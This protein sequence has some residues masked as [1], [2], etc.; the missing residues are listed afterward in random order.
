MAC[1]GKHIVI[2]ATK[3]AKEKWG[4]K[5]YPVKQKKK[6]YCPSCQ[7]NIKKS[8]DLDDNDPLVGDL[9]KETI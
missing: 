7:L 8:L 6:S 4:G 2:N 9:K 3:K 1:L 5:E